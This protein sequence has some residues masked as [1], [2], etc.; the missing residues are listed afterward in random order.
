MFTS[1][2]KKLHRVDTA[3]LN[4]HKVIVFQAILLMDAKLQLHNIIF[5]ILY[6][7]NRFILF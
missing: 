5:R 2:L 4:D 3:F 1:L 7:L 6:G